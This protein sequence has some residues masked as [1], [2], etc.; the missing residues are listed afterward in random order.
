MP[1]GISSQAISG[2]SGDGT[3]VSHNRIGTDLTGE[4][5]MPFNGSAGVSIQDAVD[6]TVQ[7]NVIGAHSIGIECSYADRAVINNNHIGVS[8][9]G[10]AFTYTSAAES[11]PVITGV[12][13]LVGSAGKSVTI[14]G[15]R[16]RLDD[17]VTFD[18]TPA[19]V[20]FTSPGTHVVRIPEL[21]LGKTS[22]T[23][24]DLGGHA[25][26]TGPIFTVVEPQPPQIASVT[27]ATTR[28]ENEVALDGSGFRPG[29][30]FTIGD[31]PAAIVTMTY[32]RVVLRVPQLAAGSYEV[33]VLNA[34]S[35]IAA[36]GPQL[37]IVAAGLA[38]IRV[39]PLCTTTEGGTPMT[40]TGS[41]FVTGATVTFDGA[42]AAGVVVVDA[43]TITLT[44]PPLPAGAPRIVV[45]NPDGDT[46]SLTNAF[47]VTSP[48]DP[49]GCA[50][51]VRPARH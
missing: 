32:S 33:D 16:F 38:V 27:P 15:A 48:F 41:G 24:T 20:L 31:Q 22:I 49:N 29:Y 2:I 46:A 25:S 12:D 11:S 21:P 9:S 17:A 42:T 7:N 40:I 23:V 10:T 37:K 43:Q 18:A 6:V 8:A 47:T 28:P 14:S 30:T 44:L 4:A 51:R 5:P 19:T 36:V 39:A 34:S 13:P 1:R 50:S 26:T 3:D 35:K 45:T